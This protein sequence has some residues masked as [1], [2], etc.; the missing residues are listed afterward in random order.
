MQC[1]KY[2]LCNLE[3]I[4]LTLSLL[5]DNCYITKS[6]NYWNVKNLNCFTTLTAKAPFSM[7]IVCNNLVNFKTEII[8]DFDYLHLG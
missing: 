3:L 7:S 5:T 8:I 2:S 6:G 1:E 4:I